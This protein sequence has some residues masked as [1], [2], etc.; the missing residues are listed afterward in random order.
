MRRSN[1]GAPNREQ[2]GLMQYPHKTQKPSNSGDS[3][4][5]SEDRYL[6]PV[7]AIVVGQSCLAM[8]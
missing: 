5:E 1:A 8:M 4:Q 2:F 7:E 3:D 6:S